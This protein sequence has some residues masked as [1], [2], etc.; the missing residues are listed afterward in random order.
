MTRI[1]LVE[2][3]LLTDKHLLAEYKEIT[4]PF[5]KVLK[6]IKNG[7][8]GDVVIPDRYCLGKGHETFFFNKLM[9][10]YW[11]YT[12]LFGELVARGF[13]VD[14]AKFEEIKRSFDTQLS[15]TIYWKDY[16]PTPEEVYLNMARL[17]I[18]SDVAA[19]KEEIKLVRFLSDEEYLG[20]VRSN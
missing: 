10:L 4:R 9:W 3:E 18:R 1:N 19:A 2:P 15:D 6:R 14:Y 11:R 16:K 20:L 13:N 7:T 5:N 8:M 12:D 17:V